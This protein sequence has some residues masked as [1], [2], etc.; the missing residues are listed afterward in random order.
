M[1][2]DKFDTWLQAAMHDS[3]DY[4]PD[5]GFTERVMAALPPA[6]VVSER[7]EKL[8]TWAAGLAA[9]FVGALP[10]PWAEILG[11]VQ[12]ADSTTWVAVASAPALIVTLGALAWGVNSFRQQA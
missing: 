9:A 5:N 10:L 7:K 12:T 2:P 8:L 4:L 3:D 6:P 1:N 11:A